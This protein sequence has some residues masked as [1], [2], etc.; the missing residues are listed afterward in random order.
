MDICSRRPYRTMYQ[1]ETNQPEFKVERVIKKKDY[2]LY[3][4]WKGNDNSFNSSI[5]KKDAII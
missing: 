5:N 2:K 3:V 4:S 1:Q